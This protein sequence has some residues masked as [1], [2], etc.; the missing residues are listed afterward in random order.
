MLLDCENGTGGKIGSRGARDGV[1]PN[2]P[3]AKVLDRQ[4]WHASIAHVSFV[5]RCRGGVLQTPQ[6]WRRSRKLRGGRS[7]RVRFSRVA[8]S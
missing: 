5:S 1:S 8:G 4:Q 3:G 2:T 7:A 6:L